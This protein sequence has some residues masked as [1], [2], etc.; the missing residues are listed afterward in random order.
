MSERKKRW[1]RVLSGAIGI[2]LLFVIA[3]GPGTDLVEAVDKHKMPILAVSPAHQASGVRPD[4]VITWEANTTAPEYAKLVKRLSKGHFSVAVLADKI[5]DAPKAIG[6]GEAVAAPDLVPGATSD[7]LKL[8]RITFRP[9]RNLERYTTY[10]AILNIGERKSGVRLWKVEFEN[11]ALEVDH[12]IVRAVGGDFLDL[13]GLGR[14]AVN[15]STRVKTHDG[16]DE[17]KGPG[18]LA[19]IRPGDRVKVR[20][21][22]GAALSIKVEEYE[23]ELVTLFTT[24][25]ALF[26]PTNVEVRTENPSPR[27]TERAVLEVVATDD[28]G[29]PAR[30][31]AF[32]VTASERGKRLPASAVLTENPISG[33]PEAPTSGNNPVVATVV[34]SDREAEVVDLDIEVSGPYNDSRD[35]HAFSRTLSFRPGPPARVALKA[36]LETVAGKEISVAGQVYDQYD[37]D[38][39]DGTQVEV[40]VPGGTPATALTSTGSFLAKAGAPTRRGVALV[41]AA[42][43]GGTASAST[44]I[45]VKPDA[46]V[47]AAISLSAGTLKADGSDS[48]TV[49][50][51]FEDRYGN[52]VDGVQA[53]FSSSSP[54]AV[55]TPARAVSDS[56]G[57]AV[58]RLTSNGAS[59]IDVRVTTSDGALTTS[60]AEQGISPVKATTVAAKLPDPIRM[61]F[62]LNNGFRSWNSPG[63]KFTSPA[64]MRAQITIRFTGGTYTPTTFRLFPSLGY[65][66]YPCIA[67]SGVVTLNQGWTYEFEGIGSDDRGVSSWEAT[68]TP[69]ELIP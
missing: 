64:M 66:G 21:R 10:A 56:D 55:Y 8:V 67:V 60:A 69:L 41:T 65:Q 5:G 25:S 43:Q 15:A 68:I 50:A 6:S 58:S 33:P 36:P 1:M 40:S 53:V 7:D 28:Y 48:I 31:V 34:A 24:G 4:A 52:P 51:R 44:E 62:S 3:P 29:L 39:D 37:N 57:V 30:D 46:P 63:A 23:K 16:E 47:K 11:G 59:D 2:V 61:A 54:S 38:S 12:G 9:Q 45:R 20:V 42:A 49:R 19:S 35:R 13:F 22:D 18:A 17:R 26:E 27:V 32:A 14:V